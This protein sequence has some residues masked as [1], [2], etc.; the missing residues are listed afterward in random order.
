MDIDY[1]PEL[2]GNGVRLRELRRSDIARRASLGRSREIARGFGE[3]LDS[4]EPM[5]EQD[6]AEELCRRFGPGPHWVIADQHDVLIGVVRLAP[7]DAAHRSARLG[8]G[9]LD[10]AR[11]GQGLGTEAI[12]LA[13]AYGFD[14]LDLH[15]VSL[16]VLAD[17]T[18]AVA[19]YTRCGFVVEGRFRDTLLRGGAWHDD[20]SM[21]IR[22]P[23]WEAQRTGAQMP[24][25]DESL[26]AVEVLAA[27]VAMFD[28]GDP[29]HAA[30]VVATDHVDHQGLGQGPIRGVD[31]FAQVV[32]ASHAGCEQQEVTIEDIF[33]TPDRAV[34]RIRWQG[35]R[36]NGERVDRETIDIIGVE[37]G[38]AVEHWGARA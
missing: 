6:A 21:A 20:L 28:S 12:R 2:V 26:T 32:A 3:D 10:A 5:T 34:A 35:R 29:T 25:A 17:N 23:Q 24:G 30:R 18:R 38:R 13:L 4:D 16:T 22:K 9:I 19:A 27:M 33:G 37:N 1:V 31:G 7:I 15:R 8:I 11:L 14:D 36:P